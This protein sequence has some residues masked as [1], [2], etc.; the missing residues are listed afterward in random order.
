MQPS[1]RICRRFSGKVGLKPFGFACRMTAISASAALML[2]RFR[3]LIAAP[4]DVVLF[5]YIRGCFVY[6]LFL[7]VRFKLRGFSLPKKFCLIAGGH[8]TKQYPDVQSESGQPVF[9][10]L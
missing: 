10:D 4:P 5:F 9:N 1:R 6:C 7:S 3:L 8:K 2:V